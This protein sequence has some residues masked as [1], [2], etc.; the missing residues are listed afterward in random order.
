MRHFKRQG[1]KCTLVRDKLYV[2]D[3]LYDP[4]TNSWQDTKRRPTG[5]SDATRPVV[6]DVPPPPRREAY[7]YKTRQN[8][9][10]IPARPNFETPNRYA[11]LRERTHEQQNKHKASPLE[12]TAKRPCDEMS[13]SITETVPKTLFELD[14]PEE[15]PS[16]S[17]D[18]NQHDIHVVN[19]D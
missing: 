6:N 12:V 11:P 5:S 8:R 15:P 10:S 9:P 14:P 17:I 13:A 1:H 4:V 7:A 3:F 2:N 19:S 16:L 18:S